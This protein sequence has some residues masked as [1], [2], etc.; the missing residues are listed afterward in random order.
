MK[1]FLSGSAFYTSFDVKKKELCK[2]VQY[3]SGERT[4]TIRRA[5]LSPDSTVVIPVVVVVEGAVSEQATAEGST[6]GAR[7]R[8]PTSPAG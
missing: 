7:R 1:L 2:G 3:A 5:L 6:P 8:P 4:R